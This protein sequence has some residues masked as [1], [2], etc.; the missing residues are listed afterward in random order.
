MDKQKAER[1]ARSIYAQHK[2]CQCFA[3]N[4][5]VFFSN[6]YLYIIIIIIGKLCGGRGM[7]VACS[8]LYPGVYGS[9]YSHM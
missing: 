7:V 8:P 6:K 2:H 1:T 4:F 3:C 9:A 5:P